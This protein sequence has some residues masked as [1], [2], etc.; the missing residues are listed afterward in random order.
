MN[1]RRDSAQVSIVGH[2]QQLKQENKPHTSFGGCLHIQEIAFHCRYPSE[3]QDLE[4]LHQEK[5][6]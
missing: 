6:S 3:K 4:E 5:T 2:L 1:L